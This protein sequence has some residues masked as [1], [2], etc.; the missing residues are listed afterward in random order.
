MYGILLA[1]ALGAGVMAQAAEAATIVR[2]SEDGGAHVR[3]AASPPVIVPAA[4]VQA[5]QADLAGQTEPALVEAAVA[6][7]VGDWAASDA[8][9][10]AAIAAVA[11]T[12]LGPDLAAAVLAG[13]RSANADATK[14][15]EAAT[16]AGSLPVNAGSAPAPA[17]LAPLGG[18]GGGGTQEL[19]RSGSPTRF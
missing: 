12:L 5:L 8:P 19:R 18:F 6:R 7:I 10:A 4:C 16:G 14:E 17:M 9:L 15:I 3:V 13:A 11:M 1:A 2:L